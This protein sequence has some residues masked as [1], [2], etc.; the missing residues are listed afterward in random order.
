MPLTTP[1]DDVTVASEVLVLLQVPPVVAFVNVIVVP[2]HKVVAPE[3][4]AGKAGM[5]FTVTGFVAI[6]DPQLLLIA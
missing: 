5:V 1:P 4:A 2:V 3:I 6:A